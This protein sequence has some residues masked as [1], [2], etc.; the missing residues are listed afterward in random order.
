M[1]NEKYN[2]KDLQKFLVKEKVSTIEQLKRVLGTSVRMT[3]LRK[4]SE[5]G[6][7]TS[8]S[9]NAKFYT[10]KQLCEFDTDGLWSNR[11][12]WFSAY[13]TLLETGRAIINRSPAGFSVT[14]LDDTVH[15]STKQALLHL[16]KKK[17]IVR[18]KIDGVFVYFPVKERKRQLFARKG[19][20]DRRPLWFFYFPAGYTQVH[21]ISPQPSDGL[22]QVFLFSRHRQYFERFCR[23]TAREFLDPREYP[24]L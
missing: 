15:V 3:V 5:L 23:S 1:S 4:L 8:Y 6:Y 9:H 24:A 17:L 20:G 19:L 14:E 10:L 7:Q 16:Y 13:G 21:A 11:K 12:V 22:L 18:E 2:A